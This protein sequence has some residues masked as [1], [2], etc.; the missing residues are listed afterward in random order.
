MRGIRAFFVRL[1]GSF[2]KQLLERDLAEEIESN[3]QLHIADNLRAGMNP[4][5]ARRVALLKLGGIEKTKEEYRDRGSIPMLETLVQDL[6]YGLRMLR[7]SPAFTAAAVLSLALGIGANTAIFSMIDALMLRT[8]PVQNPEQLVM[9]FVVEPGFSSDV[10]SA[11]S[12]RF[13]KYRDLGQVFAAVSGICLIDR[14]NVVV[15]GPGGGVDAGLA[16]VALVSGNYFSTL[17][18]D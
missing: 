8:L 17:G 12:R 7:R 18:V 1:A 6:R 16:R 3:L 11:D 10:Q 15:N 9:F 13:Q 5:D 14:F 2:R 4:D